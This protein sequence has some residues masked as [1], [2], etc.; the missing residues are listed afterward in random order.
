MEKLITAAKK[1]FPDDFDIEY[2]IEILTK[3]PENQWFY[4]TNKIEEN[5]TICRELAAMGIIAEK[6]IPK[7]HDNS[8]RG[9]R[10]EF[11]YN[12]DM[13]F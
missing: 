6:K 9:F 13:S 7:W 2:Y 10:H 3:N 8:F 12:A 11:Y 1:A 5:Y 4:P